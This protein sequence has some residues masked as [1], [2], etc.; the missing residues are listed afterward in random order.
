M[1]VDQERIERAVRE[2]LSAIGEDPERDGLQRTPARVAE[3]YAEIC[4]GLSEKPA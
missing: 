1:T 3:M 2:I 4:S